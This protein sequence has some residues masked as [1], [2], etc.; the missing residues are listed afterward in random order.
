[1]EKA[2][3]GL[4]MAFGGLAWTLQ[5]LH[6]IGVPPGAA[7]HFSLSMLAGAVALGSLFWRERRSPNR[8]VRLISGLRR[9]FSTLPPARVGLLLTLAAVASAASMSSPLLQWDPIAIWAAK[10]RGLIVA[11]SLSEVAAS[12]HPH[13]P[14]GLPILMAGG[15]D[16]AGEPGLKLIGPLFAIG[17]AA[18][19]LGAMHRKGFSWVGV[20]TTAA[21]VFVPFTLSYTFSPFADLPMGAVYVAS[22]I[23]LSEYIRR[24]DRGFLWL[25]ALLLGAAAL[26][27]VEA[28]LP[29][30]VNLAVLLLF[31]R[32][33]RTRDALLYLAV[34]ALAWTPWQVIS[35]VALGIDGGF[36][37][38]I[39]TPAE[40]VIRGTFD[41]PR[42]GAILEYFLTRTIRWSWWGFTFPITA[43][44]LIVLFFRDKRAAAVLASLLAG[45]LAVQVAEYYSSVNYDTEIAGDKLMYFLE[46]GWDRM[47][48]HWAPL[49]I[50]AAGLAVIALLRRGD[51]ADVL[52]TRPV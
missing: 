33:S 2:G 5:I 48:V 42:V 21:I 36:S 20:L 7:A 3:L 40:D 35:R 15:L 52:A 8:S 19:V 17:L 45:N 31:A 22:A 47:T 41:W 10:A 44:G 13:Y 11:D 51:S 23:Y 38:L 12:S 37:H 49:G 26:V 30:A 24:R 4:L 50:Y 34:F 18:I 43:A 46:S 1:M 29:F 16:F 39:L 32:R 27:R 14:I 25:S 28:P 6:S 9:L